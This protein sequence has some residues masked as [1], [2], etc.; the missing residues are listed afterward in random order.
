MSGCQE[1]SAY[2]L[3]IC[4]GGNTA[5]WGIAVKSRVIASNLELLRLRQNNCV[6]FEIIASNSKKL[7]QTKFHQ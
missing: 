6:E 1:A 2:L 7:R 3:W 4:I 5:E